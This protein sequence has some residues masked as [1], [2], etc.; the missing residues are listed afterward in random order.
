MPKVKWGGDLDAEAVENAE[1][2]QSYAGP[3][4]PSGVYRFRIKFAQKT[5]SSKKNPM[6]KVLLILDGSFKEEHK[7]FDG[8]P[9]WEQ[10]PVMASTAFRVR[11]FCDALNVSAKDFMEKTLVDDDGNIQKIGKLKIADE[12]LLVLYKAMRDNDE[13][14][15]ERLTRPKKGP[16]F[17][18][19]REEDDEDG[20]GDDGEDAGEGEDGEDP[21]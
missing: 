12:D 18:P 13:E 19:F 21:F 7:K 8:C 3:I 6:V 15:G 10:I 5:V 1:S 11:E 17:L 14:Y 16:G 9:V 4:P 20:E 2:N